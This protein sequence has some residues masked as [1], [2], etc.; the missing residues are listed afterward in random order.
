MYALLCKGVMFFRDLVYVLLV[1][2]ILPSLHPSFVMFLIILFIQF[3]L[4]CICSS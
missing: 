2:M 3:L 1:I 4:K